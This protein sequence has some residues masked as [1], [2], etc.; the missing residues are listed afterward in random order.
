MGRFKFNEDGRFNLGRSD[1]A[2]EESHF[3]QLELKCEG[4]VVLCCYF[5]VYLLIYLHLCAPHKIHF[6][7]FRDENESTVTKR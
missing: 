6:Y 2:H 5:K 3:G 4:F 7:P 1:V